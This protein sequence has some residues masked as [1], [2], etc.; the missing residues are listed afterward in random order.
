MVAN[1]AL[2]SV[3]AHSTVHNPDFDLGAGFSST[4]G[5]APAKKVP[6]PPRAKEFDEKLRRVTSD[7]ADLKARVTALSAADGKS[8]LGESAKKYG[9]EVLSEEIE[10]LSRLAT[11]YERQL[12]EASIEYAELDRIE[13]IVSG[14]TVPNV[15]VKK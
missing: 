8:K 14:D 3:P 5:A 6:V 7:I 12:G 10:L 9:I 15:Q 4:E 13:R 2:A 1:A 11:H